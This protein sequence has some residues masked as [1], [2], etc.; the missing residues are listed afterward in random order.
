MNISQ[1]KMCGGSLR[2]EVGQTVT[3]CEYCG[4]QQTVSLMIDDE[5]IAQLYERANHFRRN[6]DYDKALAVYELILNEN[7]ED[8]EAYWSVVLCRYGIEY[9]EDKRTGRRIPTINRAQFTSIFADDDYKLALKYADPLQRDLYEQE[10]KA[11]DEIQKNIL[12]I[13]KDE[14]PYDVFICYKDKDASGEPTQDRFTALELYNRLTRENFKVFFAYVTLDEKLGHEFEPY[15]FAALQSAK[16]MI[17]LGSRPEYFK[18]AW[19][20]NEWSRYL[21]LIKGGA[22]KTLICAY[23][24]MD[25][26]DLPDELSLQAQDMDKMG[27][28]ENLV[29]NVR[30]E[31]GRNSDEKVNT[32][33]FSVTDAGTG[34]VKNYVK[35]AFMALEDQ[36][37]KD[38]ETY[39]NQALNLDPEC[40]MAYAG[41]LLAELRV[42]SLDALGKSRIDFGDSVNYKRAVQ[43]ADANLKRT[44]Q[45]S[46]QQAKYRVACNKMEHSYYEA[47]L[48]IFESIRYQ[49]SMEKARE[50]QRKINDI[51]QERIAQQQ[52]E[53]R[54]RRERQ[55]REEQ[56]R[57]ERQQR[58]EQERIE[59]QQREEQERREKQLRME[60]ERRLEELIGKRNSLVRKA[61]G[62]Q[63]QVALG[64]VALRYIVIFSLL[65]T[66]IVLMIL[67]ALVYEVI[68]SELFPVLIGVPVI[69]FLIYAAVVLRKEKNMEYFI[70]ALGLSLCP[71]VLTWI[72]ILLLSFV[73]LLRTP[74]HKRDYNRVKR[75]I[76]PCHRQIE[77]ERRSFTN[78]QEKCVQTTFILERHRHN[79]LGE[80]GSIYRLIID[81]KDRLALVAERAESKESLLLSPGEHTLVL[82]LERPRGSGYNRTIK[83]VVGENGSDTFKCLRQCL[84]VRPIKNHKR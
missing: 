52:R 44:L 68:D 84:D 55:Q 24:N 9:V 57:I 40:G 28:M 66:F 4:R 59:R 80:N 35:R 3:T 37:W 78:D 45:E 7:N 71:N 65:V 25:A 48:E 14:E 73:I 75:E 15:I 2:I 13:V 36:L 67:A 53:A 26:Y 21:A 5:K 1:C 43:F 47:A 16:V 76:A 20:K 83:I 81:G 23:K 42:S 63:K 32:T 27:F 39:L 79:S 34:S 10:A 51:E 17:V 22:K 19:V 18:A 70:T 6:N 77:E 82:E 56:E 64:K 54:E 12:K 69:S 11:I 62:I 29:Y 50:C 49:D 46:L 41:K 60:H 74:K 61:S 72:Y 33:V 8:A 38:A 58:E 31:I 30:R